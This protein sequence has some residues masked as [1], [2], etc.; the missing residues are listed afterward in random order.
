[1]HEHVANQRK[2]YAHKLS[3][4]L[5]SRFGL[6]AFEDLNTVGMVK[7][8]NLAKSIVDAGWH[9]LVQFTKY[10]AESAGRV[11]KQVDPR[12]TSQICSNCGEVVKKELKERTH[13]CPHCGF[14]ADRDVNAAINILQR[15]TA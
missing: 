9:Q 3:R 13:H 15:A 8:H 10:K 6:I 1:M 4:N 7:N 14:V 12:N 5:V 11:V 2:D